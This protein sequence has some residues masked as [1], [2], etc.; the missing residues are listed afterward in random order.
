MFKKINLTNNFS[1]V[2]VG[3]HFF[4]LLKP[5]KVGRTEIASCKPSGFS[6]LI[7]NARSKVQCSFCSEKLPA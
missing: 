6:V 2:S 5:Q 4:V 1:C 7:E 3:S